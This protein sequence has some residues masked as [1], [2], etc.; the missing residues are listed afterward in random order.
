M[1]S[2]IRLCIRQHKAFHVA[3]HLA[4]MGSG[5]GE[6]DLTVESE[7]HLATAD[8]QGPRP[9]WDDPNYLV[10]TD[11]VDGA[12]A[13]SADLRFV[14]ETVTGKLQLVVVQC[15]TVGAGT[16]KGR[17]RAAYPKDIEQHLTQLRAC[18]DR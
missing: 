11:P 18:V 1:M 8:K 14:V 7:T 13:P 2:Y 16:K 9:A 4:G 10:Y 6:F 17:D 12:P 3:S 5:Q 15:K